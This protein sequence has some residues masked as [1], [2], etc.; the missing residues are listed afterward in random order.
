LGLFEIQAI[1]QSSG[2]RFLFWARRSGKLIANLPSINRDALVKDTADPVPVLAARPTYIRHLVLAALCVIT[3]INYIQRNSIGGA[4]TTIRTDLQLTRNDTGDAMSAFFLTYALCQVPSGWLAQRWGGRRALT[5]YAAGWSIVM[6]FTA[7]AT[8]LPALLGTRWAMGALQS[9]IFPCCTMILAAWYPSTRRGFAAAVL[10]SFM[11]IGGVIAA[12]VTGLLIGPLGWRWLFVLY[13]LPGLAWA[14]WFARWFRNR[15][16]EHP[17][18]NTAELAIIAPQTVNLLASNLRDAGRSSQRFLDDAESDDSIAANRD[19]LAMAKS[20]NQSW[21]RQVEAEVGDLVQGVVKPSTPWLVIFLS[22]ALW[23]ICIQQF[24]RA[25]S[26]RF[27]DMWLPTYLQE[28]RGQTREAANLWTSLPLWAGVIGGLLGGILSDF[29]LARTRSRRFARQ[30][31]AIGSITLALFIWWLAS[32]I[33]DVTG[34]V[35]LA[36]LG[37]LIFTFSSPCAYALTMDMGGRN[38]G[39][40]FGTVNMA[41]NL[42][43]W[44]FTKFIPRVVTWRGW[45][46]ALLVFAGLHVL[47]IVCWLLLNPNGL[48]GE[49]ADAATDS[50]E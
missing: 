45:D 49:R 14:G 34:A 24:C 37:I 33:P 47:A 27:F 12:V 22:S 30:G 41:G 26:M 50:K 25:G 3:T 48:I 43:A 4:E 13:A 35:L 16:Q 19:A 44:A 9:G 6:A 28:V 5:I 2:G 39:V 29:V 8:N 40:I 15:P 18:V 1:S 10:N 31:V 42:G 36:A 46:G 38:L 7:A 17:A 23:L 21:D 11:L 20:A 32:L